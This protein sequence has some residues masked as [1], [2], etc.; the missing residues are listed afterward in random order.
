MLQSLPRFVRALFAWSSAAVVAAC[1][2]A[3]WR[4]TEVRVMAALPEMDSV[5][6]TYLERR[7]ALLAWG[8]AVLVLLAWRLARAQGALARAAGWFLVVWAML[9][10]LNGLRW[11]IAAPDAM[12]FGIL[13]GLVVALLGTV[14]ATRPPRV[15][16]A[17]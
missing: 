8:E 3:A 7:G 12:S 9:W 14:L 2:V 1:G 15:P 11:L 13:A 5:G 17:D 10:T 6:L 16:L 4:G